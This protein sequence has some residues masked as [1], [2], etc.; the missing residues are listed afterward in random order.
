MAH[1]TFG[2]SIL[3]AQAC[4]LPVVGVRSGAMPDRVPASLG[5][6]ARPDDGSDFASAIQTAL[7][8]DLAGMGRRARQH[9]EGAFG[10]DR[11]FRRVLGF[12]TDALASRP[13]PVAQ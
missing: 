3:E 6:L 4:G 2:I 5:Y 11:T 10:W 1:E 7:S 12:Y 9:V 13:S 8:V